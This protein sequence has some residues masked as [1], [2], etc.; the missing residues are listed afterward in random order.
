MKKSNIALCVFFLL[1]LAVLTVASIV[2]P[3]RKT[4]ES[5]N[6]ELAQMPVINLNTIFD[7][8]DNG[9]TKGYE[10]FVTDQ[11]VWRDGWISIKTVFEK[12][13][14]KTVFNGVYIADDGY[15]IEYRSESDI[16]G[17]KLELINKNIGYV[18]EYSDKIDEK[19]PGESVVAI[20]PTAALIHRDK[21]PSLADEYDWA[22]LLKKTEETV[23][24]SYVDIYSA[25]AEH[26]DE[27][28]YYRTDH[29]W[30]TDG[31]YY[32]YVEIIKKFGFEPLPKD[33]FNRICVTNEFY[34][35]IIS[36]VN[37]K[38][39]ADEIYVYEPEDGFDVTVQYE[40]G[41]KN[42]LFNE[43]KLATKDKYAY[44]LGGNPG[45]LKIESH[46]AESDRV[47]V[48][49]KD[50]YANCMIPFLTAHFAKIYVIDLREFNVS[51]AG[52]INTEQIP[53]MKRYEI[54]DATDSLIL[55]NASS[56]IDARELIKLP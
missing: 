54:L 37:M 22:S 51:L 25:L 13:L 10:K 32:A 21:L 31:A 30:T 14:G 19:L 18:K 1:M 27:Y 52:F 15:F 34:G 41:D 24:D 6:R 45:F 42:T 38:T 2:N 53:A 36:K 48:I 43:E 3:V 7:T 4:S 28:I 44:F 20:A 11:F 23:G 35:T 56:F 17:E 5:E 26:K 50:S 55:Y 12:L 9:F 16:T 47:L 8:S 33:K 40:T 49:A 39:E 29:H 46:N